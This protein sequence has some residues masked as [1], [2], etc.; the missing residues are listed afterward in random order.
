MN[1]AKGHRS[2]TT[3]C[4]RRGAGFTLIELLVVIAVIAILAALLL[5][6]LAQSKEKARSINCL[7]NL[8]QLG[9]TALL[10]A[11][12]EVDSLPWSERHWT[13]PTTQSGPL[14]YTD[15]AAAN[16]HPNA[17]FQLRRFTGQDDR[18]WQCPSAKEDKALTVAG[19]NSPLLGYMGNMFAIGVTVTPLAIGPDILPKKRSSLIAPSRAKLFADLGAN[20]QGVWVS[21]TYRNLLSTVS[22]VP[23]PLHRASL[24]VVL[25]DGH[26]AQISRNEFQ[27]PGGPSVPLQD[28]PNQNWWRDGAVLQLP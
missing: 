20:V 6:A 7:S 16:F 22:V 11:D 2:C 3:E 23:S 4:D 17:Y 9:L 24:N 19:D 1:S 13:A 25:A 18:F 15:S 12:D 26:A 8:R 5:P 14:N 10:Y 28:E 27:Q 21:T